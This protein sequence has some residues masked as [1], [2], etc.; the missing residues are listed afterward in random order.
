[1]IIKKRPRFES[2]VE[3]RVVKYENS[4]ALGGGISAKKGEVCYTLAQHKKRRI[5]SRGTGDCT[6]QI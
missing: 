4:Q 1:M 6:E 2:L 3:I 5:L